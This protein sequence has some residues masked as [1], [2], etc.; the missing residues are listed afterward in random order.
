MRMNMIQE[1]NTIIAYLSEQETVTEDYDLAILAGNSL[2]Y[3]ADEVIQLYQQGKVTAVMLVGGIGHATSFL[4]ENFRKQGV[5]V[6]SLSETDMY[7]EYFNLKYGIEADQF[8]TESASTNSGENARFSLRKLQ[9]AN[10]QPKKVLLLQDP[11]LQRRIKAAFE[12]EWQGTNTVFTNYVPVV[13]FIK[14][15][16][17][18]IVFEE[19]RLNGLWE[20]DYFLSL[21]LGEIPRLRN[22]KNGYGPKGR[23]YIG[24][25]EIPEN[26]IHSYEKLCQRYAYK[27]KR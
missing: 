24:A 2:P 12:K 26:V 19:N 14:T 16:D 27:L 7:L 1:W 5:I 25:I 22:D 3:L 8:L 23:N 18:T 15:S 11:L 20:Q 21:A 17:E 10:I 4:R 9:A 6:S 13:P